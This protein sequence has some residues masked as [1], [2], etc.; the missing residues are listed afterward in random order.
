MIPIAISRPLLL[1][2]A[3]VLLAGACPLYQANYVL[4][5]ESSDR[6]RIGPA[7]DGEIVLRFDLGGTKK[8]VP[9]A[10][11]IDRIRIERLDADGKRVAL[12]PDV[13]PAYIRIDGLAAISDVPDGE[14]HLAECTP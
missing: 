5:T 6:L 12:D 2:V 8:S 1:P 4:Q 14:W 3:A 7:A 11:V 9:L 10:Q 13:A